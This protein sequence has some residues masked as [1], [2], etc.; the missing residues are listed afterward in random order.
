MWHRIGKQGTKYWGER[1]AGIIFTDGDSVLLLRRAEKGDNKGRWGTPGGKAEDGETMLG[2]AQRETREEIGKLPERARRITHIDSTDGRHHFRTYICEVP[3]R[4]ECE[5][6]DEHDDYG[7]YGLDDVKKLNLHPKLNDLMDD[8]LSIIQSK[9]KKGLSEM[10]G[11][12]EFVSLSEMMGSTGAV[13]GTHPPKPP[14]HSDWNIM[15]APG[16]S[17]T[18]PKEGPIKLKKKR[19]KAR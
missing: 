3:S 19:K 13:M 16:R 14:E 8:I 4:F 18:Y 6:S 11:F 1:G 9:S 15:G 5:L 10:S 7:W 17:A 2:T 12:A